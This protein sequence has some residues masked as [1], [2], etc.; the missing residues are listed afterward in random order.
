[1]KMSLKPKAHRWPD[2]KISS[3]LAPKTKVIGGI[4]YKLEGAFTRKDAA[5]ASAQYH[6]S[7]WGMRA[8]VVI[9]NDRA[10][11]YTARRK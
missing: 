11:L 5:Y 9:I 1:M 2:K 3:S 7:T 6:R 10:H 8:R 4:T